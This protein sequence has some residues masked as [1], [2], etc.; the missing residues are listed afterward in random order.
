[1]M[2]M[3][4]SGQCSASWCAI[5]TPGPNLFFGQMGSAFI[6]K[7]PDGH[8]L[9]AVAGRTDFCIDLKAALKLHLVIAAKRTFEREIEVGNMPPR[10]ACG[11]YWT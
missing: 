3:V 4:S 11:E 9:E 5:E 10:F 6:A 7:C 8:I 2:P 1:M